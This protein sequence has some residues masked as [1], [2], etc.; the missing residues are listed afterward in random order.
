M[1]KYH[2]PPSMI[3]LELTEGIAVEMPERMLCHMDE[4]GKQGVSFAMDDYGSGN[5]NCS[6]LIRFPFQE[7]KID[8]E[9]VWAYFNSETA[10]I[11]L[12]SEIRTLKKLGRKIVVEGIENREQSEAM[13]RLGVDYIQG[14]YY[15]KPMPEA[16]CLRYIRNFYMEPVEYGRA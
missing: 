4:L 7:V 3:T 5:S 12:E 8:K 2:I 10:K 1:E 15:G 13:E 9:I 6:Y 14:Y 11:V 16:E